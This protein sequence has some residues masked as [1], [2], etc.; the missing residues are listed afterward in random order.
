MRCASVAYWGL[1]RTRG[2]L[3]AGLVKNPATLTPA[4]RR[5]GERSCGRLRMEFARLEQEGARRLV[6][7]EENLIGTMAQNLDAVRLYGQVGTR[8]ARLAPAFEGRRVSIALA[9]RAYDLHWASQLAFRIKAGAM[10]P[11]ADDLDRLVTQPRRWRDVI[12]DI[13]AAFPDAKIVVWPFEGWAANPAP[14]LGVLAGRDVALAPMAK[15]HKANASAT[16]VELAKIAAERGDLDSAV[17]LASAGKGTRYM[18][19]DA[20][21]AWKLQEDYRADIAWLQADAGPRVTYLN[22]TEGTFGGSDMTE[23]S[24][25]DGQEK[26]VASA[27]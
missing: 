12:G 27:R 25:H 23:G 4:D 6:L 7:S 1:E 24:H 2:G 21:Q 17:R 13:E 9:I 8:L 19:F 26:G 5:L 3:L 22:P 20:A 15:I 10:L 18:P 14:L 11:A 16:A